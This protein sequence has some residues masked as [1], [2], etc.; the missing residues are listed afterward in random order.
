MSDNLKHSILPTVFEIMF[1]Y[2]G[3]ENTIIN[4][5]DARFFPEYQ[6]ISD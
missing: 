2:P 1:T 5:I 4:V 6:K 3:P